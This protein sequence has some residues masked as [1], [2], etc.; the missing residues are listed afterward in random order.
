MTTAPSDA[1]TRRSADPFRF[2]TW[3]VEDAGALAGGVFSSRGLYVLGAGGALVLASRY[4]ETLTEK[5]AG[6]AEGS[7]LRVVEE[8]GNVKAVQPMALVLFMGSLMSGDER[9]QDA[10]FTSL[11]AV[12]FANLITN[13][14]KGAFGR[15]RP[16]QNQG[17]GDFRPFSGNTSFPSGHAAT[18]FALVT[19]WL[20][21]YPHW[22]TA[23]LVVLAGGTA[24]S[25]MATRAHWFTDV[26]GGAA[27]GFLTG[28]GLSRRH[29][30]TGGVRVTP[31][32]GYRSAGVRVAF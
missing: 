29:L 20:V 15:A 25:R 7:V 5:A 26:V 2:F 13:T 22:T 19:P 1:Q 27:V 3:P 6:M 32:F 28:Y 23:G 4:D 30:H 9:F 31:R 10:A 24:F 18:V 21:Y 16:R 8:F 14:L 12:V 17:S 11:E